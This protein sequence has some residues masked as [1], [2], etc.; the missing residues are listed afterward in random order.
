MQLLRDLATEG[1]IELAADTGRG[2]PHGVDG[3]EVLELPTF[4]M[5]VSF[6]SLARRKMFSMKVTST[7]DKPPIIYFLQSAVRR[8]GC[9]A[10]A[11][12]SR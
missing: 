12:S 8:A 6:V 10:D 2:A 1:V 11:R 3:F 5:C 9:A 4:Q 7:P